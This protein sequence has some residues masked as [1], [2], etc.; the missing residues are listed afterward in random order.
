MAVQLS[1][2][3]S[4]PLVFDPPPPP[5]AS[6]PAEATSRMTSSRFVQKSPNLPVSFAVVGV[7][8]AFCAPLAQAQSIV[9]TVIGTSAQQQTGQ[10]LNGAGVGPY[11]GGLDHIYSAS[12]KAKIIFSA[13]SGA[14]LMALLVGVC[15]CCCRRKAK[16]DATNS[17]RSGAPADAQV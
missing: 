1:K 16:L 17:R 14:I 13:V 6:S 5:Q 3:C 12:P 8:A 2:L 7:L 10:S 11:P 15:I 9:N 4:R